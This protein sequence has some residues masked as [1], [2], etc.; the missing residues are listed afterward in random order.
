MEVAIKSYYRLAGFVR[1]ETLLVEILREAAAQARVAHENVVNLVGG[2]INAGYL[3][4]QFVHST[5][6]K[7][8]IERMLRNEWFTQQEALSI[9]KGVLEGLRAIHEKGIVHGDLK[10]ANVLIT[11]T[12]TPKISDFGM[13]SILSEKMFPVAFLRGSS[14]WAAP[15]VLQGRKPDYRSDLFSAG[16]IGFL[17]FTGRHPFHRDDP[18]C[19]TE[20]RDRIGDPDFCSKAAKDIKTDVPDSVSRV[21]RKLLQRNRTR[22]YGIINEV[23]SALHGPETPSMR[24]WYRGTTGEPIKV[25]VIHSLTGTMAISERPLVEAH[26][27]AVDEI[28]EQGGIMGRPIQSV[29]ED[30]A[31]EPS[32]FASKAKKLIVQDKVCSLFGCWTS[33]SRKEVLPVLSEEDHLLWYP[34]QY[35]G[36]ENSR[37]VIYTGASPNQQIMPAVDWCLETFGKRIFLVGSAYVFPEM[38][39]RII[40]AQLDD[41][42][43][44]CLGEEYRPL[45]N[46][47]FEA[48]I[49]KI[50]ATEPDVIFNTV[51]GDSN[52]ALYHQLVDAEVTSS[53]I[54]VVAVSVAEV[55][56][57]H[58]GT[59]FTTG[60]YCAWNYFQSIETPE[61]KKFVQSFKK[62]YGAERVT[63]DPIEAAYFQVHLFAKAIE[64]AGTTDVET[65][66]ESAL[67]LTFEA[68][69]GFVR[70]DPQNQHTWKVA[71]IGQIQANG[72]F[73]IVWRT[74]KPV[75]P[76]PYPKVLFPEH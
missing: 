41:R 52:L 39:N 38:A 10:P 69:S 76:E 70:I 22:R 7:E 46:W 49:Q 25:G 30:G 53:V 9:F 34:V 16:I 17:L 64:K 44:T 33:A 67:D 36:C 29:V 48:I 75:Q 54:P 20:P 55:E 60:H 21:L 19:L 4:F 11:E 32:T 72:Q 37:H 66:R 23:I 61:N 42:G 71:R 27:M 31:S 14:N 24:K 8:C 3:V 57:R 13:A 43:A 68:P 74:E 12:L 65:I 63:D 26:L 51:N 6:G 62:K 47:D 18:T 2:D 73:K 1:E 58:I 45:G 35:E 28:N 59:Q 56:L 15:E 5:L 50:K 40:K